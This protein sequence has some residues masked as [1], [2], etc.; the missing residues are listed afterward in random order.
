METVRENETDKGMLVGGDP[1]A[2]ECMSMML[3]VRDSQSVECVQ[4]GSSHHAG[5]AAGKGRPHK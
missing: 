5:Q 4:Y 1:N 2:D 3:A